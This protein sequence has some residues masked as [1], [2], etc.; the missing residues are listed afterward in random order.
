MNK[1]KEGELLIFPTDTVYGL[2]CKLYDFKGLENIYKV[3]Q[4]DI[5]KQIPV[6]VYDLIT[7][8]LLCKYRKRDIKIMKRFWP[9]ALTLIFKSSDTFYKKTKQETIAVRIPDHYIAKRLLDNYGPLWVTSCNISNNPPLSDKNEIL[10]TFKDGV[11][12]IYLEDNTNSTMKSSTILDLTGEEIKLIRQGDIT[13][14]EILNYLKEEG[15]N[16]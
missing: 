1:L 10:N 5:G 14:E 15:E 16:K 3:K 12:H 11:K 2:G 4:R 13:L 9:G 6:L 8:D 7:V